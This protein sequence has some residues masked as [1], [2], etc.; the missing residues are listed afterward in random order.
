MS[1]AGELPPTNAGA[2]ES[3]CGA[4]P[5]HAPVNHG[6]KKRDSDLAAMLLN[7]GAEM[8]GAG[9]PDG[10]VSRARESGDREQRHSDGK[11][12]GGSESKDGDVQSAGQAA[13]SAA[14]THLHQ[15]A[16]EQQT[17]RTIE[18]PAALVQRLVEFATVHRNQQGVVEFTLGLQQAVLGGMRIQLSAYGNRRVGLTVKSAGQRAAVG[19]EEIAGLIDSL[20]KRNVE[21]VEVVRA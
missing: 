5:P 8:S 13:P 7:G 18:P 1:R 14:A 15:L 9:L 10:F 3:P 2:G 21:V 4:V 12:S 20:R 19:D 16:T 11:P 6:G 17:T